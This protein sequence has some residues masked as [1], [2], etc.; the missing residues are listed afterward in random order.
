MKRPSR[1]ALASVLAIALSGLVVLTCTATSPPAPRS[2]PVASVEAPDPSTLTAASAPASAAIPASASASASATR[3]TPASDPSVEPVASAAAPG[4]LPLPR[5]RAA[6]N[7]LLAG[8]RDDHVRVVWLGDSHTAADLWT[9]T[10]RRR[11]VE[12]LGSGGPGFVHI[13]WGDNKY[14]HEGVRVETTLKWQVIPPKYPTMEKVS[15]GVFGLGGVR[16]VQVDPDARATVEVRDGGRGDSLTWDLAYREAGE[17]ALALAATVDGADQI[18]HARDDEAKA[19]GVRHHR[20]V[21]R[22]SQGKLTVGAKTGVVQLM[23]VV[24]EGKTPGLVLDTVGLNGARVGTFLARDEASWVSELARREPNLVV[25]AFG[26]NE[27]SDVAPKSERYEAGMRRLLARVKAAASDADCLVITPMDRGGREYAPRL[28]IISLGMATAARGAGCAVWSA[29][30]AMGGPGSM[31]A[32][33]RES[34]PRA[35]RD[36]VHLT[37]RGYASLGNALADVLLRGL[38]APHEPLPRLP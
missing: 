26:T 3:P 32:W 29:T 27:S 5:F 23:G 37:A 25:L 35:A 11:L 33:S 1:D 16:L 30:T 34:P 21:S 22:G 14:R 28:E 24:V 38:D 36:G 10:V 2:V 20:F 17:A 9:N 15:D 31:D 6:A 18:V 8:R 7:A 4:A 13:G 19:G 12:R